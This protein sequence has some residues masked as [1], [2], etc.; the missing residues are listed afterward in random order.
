MSAATDLRDRIRERAI[1]AQNKRIFLV[2]G[3]DDKLVM[4]IMLKRFFQNWETRWA[5]EVA[6]NTSGNKSQLQTLLKLEPSW[7]GLVDRDEWDQEEQKKRLRES[8]N[9]LV[10]PRFCMENYLVVPSELWRAV[11]QDRQ[12][13]IQDGL[14]AFENQVLQNLERYVRHGVL[15]HVVTPLWSGLRARGFKEKL[16]SDS[17]ACVAA[18]QN[19]ADIQSVLASWDEYLNPEVLFQSF[20]ARLV[21]V[22][23]LS[24]D[25]QLRHWVHGKTFWREEV[26][27][28]MNALFGQMPDKTRRRKIFEKLPDW[29]DDLQFVLQRLAQ[30]EG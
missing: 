12:V 5:I 7:L 23:A 4:E 14:P 9:L 30:N 3:A 16:A 1:G 25:D 29:P 27:P 19:D 13:L 2:E 6:G 17:A 26:N 20:Q 22:Q 21:E 24:T 8:P 11:P 28:A 10:L 15:W 18:V